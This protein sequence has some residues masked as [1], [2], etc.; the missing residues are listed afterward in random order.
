MLVEI[1]MLKNYPAVN[2]N[3]DDTGAP[4]TCL[5]GNV[6]RGRISSQCLKRSWRT[7]PYMQDMLSDEMGIRTRKMPE[8]VRHKLEEEGSYGEFLETVQ[9]KLTGIANKD[10]KESKDGKTSQI[11]FYSPADIKAI[12]AC[13]KKL[14]DEC[15]TLE[16]FKAVKNKELLKE[17]NSLGTRP[18]SLDMALFGRMVT[19]D[20]F[21][22]VEAAMQV[23]HAMS[24]NRIQTESDFFTA[25]DDY[26]SSDIED[27]GSAMMG[28]TAYN[29]AC[30]YEYANIDIDKL[31]ENLKYSTQADAL[32][33]KELPV[34]LET[35]AFSNP[36]GKQ[37][38][39]AGQVL[40]S[41]ILV[42][43]KDRNIPIN[44]AEAFVQPAQPHGPI[45]LVGDSID[46]LR[47]YVD[48]VAKGY[49]IES[50]RFWFSLRPV[51]A[52]DTAIVSCKS[53]ADIKQKAL[54]A[55]LGGM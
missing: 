3:R 8:I 41:A 32:M 55:A 47:Q 39:F 34:L 16:A 17:L 18:I 33:Q 31:R 36:S 12:T 9:Q 15:G 23:A 35:M 54:Q 46:K 4:K 20:I 21:A 30:Y 2:L 48:A 49:G 29:S 51:T 42:E 26:L 44:Y 1:H 7:Y 53:L 5:Y 19:A 13:V 22:D 37:N 14:I 50:K 45:D 11:I 38:S 27:T 10:G 25:M 40:P 52:I 6:L 43:V 24:T 28:E